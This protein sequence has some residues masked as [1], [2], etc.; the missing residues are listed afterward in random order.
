M[1]TT[2]I[3]RGRRSMMPPPDPELARAAAAKAAAED[4]PAATGQREPAHEAQRIPAHAPKAP[5]K[6]ER[7]RS[8][9]AMLQTDPFAVNKENIP[10]DVSVEWKRHTVTGAE[11]PFYL[12]RMREQGWE[13]VDPR[14][15]TDWVPLPPS[16]DA[17]NVIKDGLILMERPMELTQEANDES[18]AAAKQQ[19]REAEQRL[20]L[21]PN[22]QL[23]RDHDGVRPRVSKEWNRPLTVED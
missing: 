20:G 9:L 7:K 15:H 22:N 5:R 21:T 13:P 3:T 2:P 17:P 23:T 4:R 10:P 6:R 18:R 14:V 8:N 16:Y 1:P 11:D 12:A 19:V